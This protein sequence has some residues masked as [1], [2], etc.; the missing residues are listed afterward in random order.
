MPFLVS[1]L[2]GFDLELALQHHAISLW[3]SILCGPLH[4]WHLAPCAQHVNVVC[5]H[6]QQFLHWGT[7]GFMFV[8]PTVTMYGPTL[9]LRGPTGISLSLKGHNLRGNNC[10][11]V[12]HYALSE[13]ECWITEIYSTLLC[14]M[15]VAHII[16]ISS[17]PCKTVYWA[18]ARMYKITCFPFYFYLQYNSQTTSQVSL[19]GCI[20]TEPCSLGDLSTGRW[21][22]ATENKKRYRSRWKTRVCPSRR[23]QESNSRIR[24]CTIFYV[25]YVARNAIGRVKRTRIYNF[26]IMVDRRC[27]AVCRV[28]AVA[29]RCDDHSVTE[30]DLYKI[31]FLYPDPE[32]LRLLFT[33]LCATRCD[34]LQTCTHCFCKNRLC[35]SSLKILSAIKWWMSRPLPTPILCL[36]P[37]NSK[38]ERTR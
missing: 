26:T 36:L 13:G 28:M 25:V 3:C 15:L 33:Q 11:G 20:H 38:T 24:R 29:Y 23:K 34:N 32:S 4:F 1:S 17:I 2:G 35:F 12:H 8:P 10:A 6:F 5:P 19:A 31:R 30:E 21:W 14:N 37:K 22:K 16:L 18:M 7:L 27:R 9:K